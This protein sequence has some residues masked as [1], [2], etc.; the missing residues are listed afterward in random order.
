MEEIDNYAG[1]RPMG[2]LF[3]IIGV[4]M[5][6]IAAAMIIDYSSV[7]PDITISMVYMLPT[8]GMILMGALT[9]RAGCVSF[10]GS[11]NSA[12]ALRLSGIAI[13]A[14]FTVYA[15]LELMTEVVLGE[16]FYDYAASI[17]TVG[18]F[19]ILIT[20]IIAARAVTWL[21]K[22]HGSAPV[23]MLLSAGI[24]STILGAYL[25]CSTAIGSGNV[26][27]VIFVAYL[28]Q[29]LLGMAVAY[30]AYRQL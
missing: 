4:I 1:I 30:L 29:M 28:C 15:I 26:Y 18:I 7:D 3:M 2:I 8:I 6:M 22:K 21:G 20:G 23:K 12:K 19:G 24:L 10:F 27:H 14:G 9:L 13:G 17:W 16:I 5:M 11:T 25:A